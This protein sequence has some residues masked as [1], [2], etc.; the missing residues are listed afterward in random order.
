MQNGGG[1]LIQ[2]RKL[3]VTYHSFGETKQA[4]RDVSFSL[5]SGETLGFLGESGSGKSTIG[6]AILG[7]IEPPHEASGEVVYNNFNVLAASEGKLRRYRWKEVAM[8]FQT[9]MNSLD[10]LVTIK[11]SFVQLLIGK[12]IADKEEGAVEIAVNLLKYVGLSPKVLDMYTFELSGGMR[13]RVSIALAIACNPKILIADEPTTALDT[14][15]QFS[16]LANMRKLKE[17]RKIDAMILITHDVEIQMIMAD[18]I[19]IT[20]KGRIVEEGSKEEMINDPKHPY[21]RLLLQ[22]VTSANITKIEAATGN[23]VKFED[24][25]DG[26]PFLAQCPYAMPKCAESFPEPKAFSKTHTVYCYIY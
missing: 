14:V 24:G 13:Q 20:L 12:G 26:C 5:N 7:M 21:T 15:N 22:S 1:S 17:E 10:P 9:A 8:I 18:R 2:V 6:W 11:K 4:V 3:N 25:K 23:N 16:V 19:A